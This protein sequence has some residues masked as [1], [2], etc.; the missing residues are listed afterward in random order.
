[1]A[2]QRGNH[3]HRREV[4]KLHP[5]PNGSF[6]FR[7]SAGFLVFNGIPLITGEDDRAAGVVSVARNVRIKRR[8]ALLGVNNND[9]NIGP[10]Q[11][12]HGHH[13]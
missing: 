2:R 4:E 7:R 8:D 3:D 13:Y 5:L 12:L 9:C 10:F 6:K 11:T 1:L